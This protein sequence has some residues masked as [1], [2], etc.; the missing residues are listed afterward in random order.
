[1]DGLN[2]RRNFGWTETIL[3]HYSSYFVTFHWKIPLNN[4]LVDNFAAIQLG[5]TV[6]A[7]YKKQLYGCN[8]PAF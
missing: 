6:A 3:G 1:M 8:D 4:V 2:L 5:H 7:M